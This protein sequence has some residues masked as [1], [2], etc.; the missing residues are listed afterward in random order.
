MDMSGGTPRHASFNR[1]D[2]PSRGR[3]P[4]S[5]CS[6]RIRHSSLEWLED[7]PTFARAGVGLGDL[8]IIQEFHRTCALHPGRRVYVWSLDGDLQ[9]YDREPGL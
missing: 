1:C 5:P 7:F 2:S 9:G 4:G 6:S 8:S 3:P